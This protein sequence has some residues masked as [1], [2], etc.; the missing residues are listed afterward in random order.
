M[1]NEKVMIVD[2]N[3]RFLSELEETLVL[4]GY[5]VTPFMNPDV[6]FHS[7]LFVKPDIILLDIPL[8]DQDVANRILSIK[9]NP[10]TTVIPIIAMIDHA[11]DQVELRNLSYCG[12][13]AYIKKP[14]R[15]LDVITRIE[16]ALSQRRENIRVN[17]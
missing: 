4:S 15:P 3:Q 13:D 17:V 16:H 8:Q 1:F 5:Y 14:F 9:E 7:L 2:S 10:D 12:I 6:L 11:P